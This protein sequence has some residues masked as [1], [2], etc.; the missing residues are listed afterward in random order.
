VDCVPLEPPALAGLP[1]ERAL[2]YHKLFAFL[3]I[4]LGA[5]HGYVGY[6]GAAWAVASVTPGL[7]PADVALLQVPMPGPGAYLSGFIFEA[8]MIA[9]LLLSISPIR[10]HYFELFYASHWLFI[11]VGMG[12]GLVHAGG[13]IAGLGAW[14]IDLFVRYYYL[15]NVQYAQEAT[16][17]RLPAG[18]VRISFPKTE[19]FRY[20]GGQY[21]F[22]CIPGLSIWQWH[23]FSI[24]SA[25]HEKEVH[26]HVRSL[27]N[28]T[29]RLHDTA[30]TTP[31]T[32]K[33]KARYCRLNAV[34][35]AGSAATNSSP[36]VAPRAACTFTQYTCA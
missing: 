31:S 17:Q 14:A 5:F 23:P 22:L 7:M 18:V 11:V 6:Y 1:F 12:A 10:R 8:S 25:P 27:G 29:R 15:A 9:M 16:V 26:L 21:V 4:A 34:L 28:W 24:S 36:R 3:A 32:M 19:A 30:S 20:K 33:V 35:N 2:A 13:I